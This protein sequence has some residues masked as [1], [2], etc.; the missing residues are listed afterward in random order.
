[1]LNEGAA[2]PEQTVADVLVRLRCGSGTHRGDLVVH[3]CETVYGPGD[4]L[5]TNIQ[6]GWSMLLHDGAGGPSISMDTCP[7]PR[8]ELA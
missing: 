7:S 3:L 1:M 2:H 6:S 4:N 5:P 8:G